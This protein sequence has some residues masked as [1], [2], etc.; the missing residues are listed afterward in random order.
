[1]KH[2]HNVLDIFQPSIV[3]SKGFVHHG[4]NIVTVARTIV[5]SLCEKQAK[6]K[7]IMYTGLMVL[8]KFRIT[9]Q[10]RTE[11]FWSHVFA[12]RGPIPRP[13]CETRA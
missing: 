5:E 4:T 3:S 8:A 11:Y 1:M 6:K 2:T 9:R 13:P 12:P 7:K 10:H